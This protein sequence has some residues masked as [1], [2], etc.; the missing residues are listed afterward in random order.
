MKTLTMLV[1]VLL[2][3][4]AEDKKPAKDEDKIQGSWKMV[5][6]QRGGENAPD[7]VVKNFRLT[8]K[9]GGKLSAVI[10]GKDQEGTYKIDTTKKPRQIE[11]TIDD[12]TVEGIYELNGD[13]LKLCVDRSARPKEFKSPEGTRIMLMNFKREKK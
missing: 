7:E 8:F 3:A 4:P 13:D 6:G 9:A 2:T 10:E 5:S 12:K 11:V 1:A